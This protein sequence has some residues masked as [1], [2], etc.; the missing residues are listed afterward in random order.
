L[1]H[2]SYAVS[3]IVELE[4]ELV[5]TARAVVEQQQRCVSTVETWL[6]AAKERRALEF[7]EHLSSVVNRNVG[8]EGYMLSHH[9]F[10]SIRGNEFD[11]SPT[12][13][14]TWHFGPG[15]IGFGQPIGFG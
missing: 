8:T 9:S 6:G 15:R 13:C 5:Q 1:D 2:E 14:W 4:T 12:Y 10:R 7:A 11:C 3:E